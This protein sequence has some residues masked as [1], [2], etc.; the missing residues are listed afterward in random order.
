MKLQSFLTQLTFSMVLLNF[1]CEKTV[2]KNSLYF[3]YLT[4]EDKTNLSSN[5]FIIKNYFFH[6]KPFLVTCKASNS[7]IEIK[8][9]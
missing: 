1:F 6:H 5:V 8:I 9:S 4:A 2:C 3:Y 7:A